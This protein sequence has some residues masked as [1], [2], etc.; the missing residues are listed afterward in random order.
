[1]GTCST[2]HAIVSPVTQ[3]SRGIHRHPRTVFTKL[4]LLWTARAA[5]LET[6]NGVARNIATTTKVRYKKCGFNLKIFHLPSLEQRFEK[7]KS[8]N[9]RFN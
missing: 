1:M 9:L 7:Q 3:K 4:R 2:N 6:V 5:G 8:I